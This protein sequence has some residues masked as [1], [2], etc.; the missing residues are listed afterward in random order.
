MQIWLTGRSLGSCGAATRGA[1]RTFRTAIA[2]L[3]TICNLRLL[4]G[5]YLYEYPTTVIDCRSTIGGV[6]VS[7]EWDLT[8]AGPALTI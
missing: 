5:S 8:T 4:R 1:Y 7:T 3:K 2:G 6:E